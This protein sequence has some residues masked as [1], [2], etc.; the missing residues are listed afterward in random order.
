MI[1]IVIPLYNKEK[2]ISRTILSALNQTYED[3][4]IIIVDDGST[5]KSVVE[6]EK[7]NNKR[8][9]IISQKNTGVS[10]ARNRGI[11][12]ARYDLIAFLDADDEWLPNH[13][14]EIVDLKTNFLE[15]QVFATNYKIVDSYGDKRFPVNT[16]VLKLHGENGIIANYFDAAINTAPPLW[17]SAIVVTKDVINAIGGF[18]M[19]VR[20]GEDLLTWAKLA[21]KY[22]IAYSKTV[23]AVYHFKA[24]TEMLDDEPMPDDND[25]VGMGLRYLYENTNRDKAAL[26]KYISLWHRMRCNLYIKNFKRVD[27]L[28]EIMKALYYN[29]VMYKNY[30]L[31]ILCIVPHSLRNRIMYLRLKKQQKALS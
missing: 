22:N 23:T 17:T 8:I 29:P 28:S 25:V 14:E 30:L 16:E 19:S 10:A 6:V 4:E 3:F 13:L 2:Y 5:D 12:E 9:R 7:F 15:C 18:P 27:A 24:Y 20:L 21:D 1:S 26:R 11:E 31:L